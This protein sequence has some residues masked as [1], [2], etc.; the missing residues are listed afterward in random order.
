MRTSH[1]KHDMAG[2]RPRIL[3][4]GANGQVGW[5]LRR[6]LAGLGEVIAASLEGEY[7]PVID[8]LDP[9]RWRV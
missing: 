4:I 5:E 3:L 8:L 9:A 7:G 1:D 2:N 6:T